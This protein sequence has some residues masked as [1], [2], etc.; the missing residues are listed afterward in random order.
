[1]CSLPLW[2]S[3]LSRLGRLLKLGKLG[4]SRLSI[5]GLRVADE[6]LA[7]RLPRLPSGLAWGLY[8][9]VCFVIFVVWTFPT[10]VLVDRLLVSVADRAEIH[11]QYTDSE[12]TWPLGVA[13]Q[14]V[15]IAGPAV[16]QPSLQ[17]TRLALQPAVLSLL[18]TPPLPLTL[19]AR[20]YGGT[21]EAVIEKREQ[22]MRVQFSLQ[23][24]ALERLPL[25]APWGEGRIVG[26]MMG[27]GSLV[28]NLQQVASLVG[29]ISVTITDGTVQA[30]PLQGFRLPSLA[31]IEVFGKAQ[32]NRGQV[33][34]T[35]LTL[36]TKGLEAHLQGRLTL[37]SPVS[38]SPIDLQLIVRKTGT[39]SAALATLVSLL[40]ASPTQPNERQAKISGLLG[41]P[42]VR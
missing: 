24:L 6:R 7:K 11:V 8:T 13:L 21:L 14:E 38:R 26:R 29:P 39:L 16:P 40:P 37:G 28:G 31:K 17:F 33:D 27:D 41:A 12:M 36:K 19:Q 9:L 35:T 22:E 1:M 10:E 32:L 23:Q 42:K 2:P 34:I 20:G 3:L 18:S 5:P 4:L 30:G 25:P 15:S